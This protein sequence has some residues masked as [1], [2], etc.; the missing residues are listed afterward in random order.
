MFKI[1]FSP[2]ILLVIGVFLFSFPTDIQA[3]TK[4]LSGID[5]YAASAEII[6]DVWEEAIHAILVYG[7]DFPDALSAVPL[8]Q[9]Y[10]RGPQNAPILL[11]QSNYIP[12]ETLKLIKDLNVKYITIIGG[13]GV[14]SSSVEAQLQAMGIE[15]DRLSGQDKY[16]TNIVAANQLDNVNEIFIVTGED[17]ADALSVAPIAAKKN[18]PIIYV[19]HNVIPDIVKE[20]LKIHNITKTYV[21]GAGSSLDAALVSELPNV[22]AINGEDKYQ[23]NLAVIDKFK[24]EMDL[25]A[26]YLT[27]GKNFADGLSGAAA[28]SNNCNPLLLVGENSIS[29]KEYLDNNLINNYNVVVL[30]D[31]IPESTIISSETID[32]EVKTI[33]DMTKINFGDI[34][35]IE[36]FDMEVSP[37]KP[38]IVE[39]K[40]K[41]KEF[42]GY[43]EGYLLKKAKN[44]KLAVGWKTAAVFY[45]NDQ[46]EMTITFGHPLNIKIDGRFEDYEIVKNGFDYNQLDEFIKSI[47]GTI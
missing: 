26:I 12:A 41:V 20:Y 45:I 36:L 2:V 24:S 30:G 18:M 17:F 13:P 38:I 19:R 8:T 40:Q 15:T 33:S 37:G 31:A 39:D 47:F 21:I 34:T 27:S 22:E 35:K 5:R 42:T 3:N 11:T 28:A 25:N 10:G 46:K 9:K 32:F 29:Q 23:R 4:N 16:E 44:P 43:L 7:E 14:I 1:R 6:S